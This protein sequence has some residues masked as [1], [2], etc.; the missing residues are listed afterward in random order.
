MTSRTNAGVVCAS[1][2]AGLLLLWCQYASSAELS[3]QSC[4]TSRYALS[5]PTTRFED[6]ADGT[7]TDTQSNLMWQR[8]SAG[9]RWAA[10]HC[11]GTPSL[12]S[13]AQALALAKSLNQSGTAFYNDWRLPQIHELA[14]IA[15][16]QCRNPRVNLTVFP[17]T[18]SADYW[19][20]TSRDPAG[21]DDSAFMLSFGAEGVKYENRQAKHYVRLVRNGP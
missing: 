19:S 20:F 7:V 12:L 6:H 14:G 15:E 4:D 16:R 8:C 13:W 2:Q 9:Q 21:L 10:G 3:T 17:E 11:S 5:T 1:V 18:P